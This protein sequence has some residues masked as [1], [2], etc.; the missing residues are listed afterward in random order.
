MLRGSVGISMGARTSGRRSLFF[1]RLRVV[2]CED[3]PSPVS[4]CAA[5][6]GLPLVP[7][8]SRGSFALIDPT[9]LSSILNILERPETPGGS[10]AGTM[11][12]CRLRTD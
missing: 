11:V 9:F 3:Q 1:C 8:V 5:T 12:D 4:S 10:C 7:G 2:F 6:R